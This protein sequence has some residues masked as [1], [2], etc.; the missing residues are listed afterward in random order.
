MLVHVI[1]NFQTFLNIS[2]HLDLVL[3]ILLVNLAQ[4][5][6]YLYVSS[7]DFILEIKQEVS[8]ASSSILILLLL[9]A[10]VLMFLSPHANV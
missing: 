4:N 5:L 6:N 3:F 10:I 8:F 2:R 9:I 7:T 1:L